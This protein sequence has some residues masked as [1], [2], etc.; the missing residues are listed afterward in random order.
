[1]K[2]RSY[3]TNCLSE[4]DRINKIVFFKVRTAVICLSFFAVQLSLAAEDSLKDHPK[5]VRLELDLKQNV[6]V[7]AYATKISKSPNTHEFGLQALNEVS[8]GIAALFYG[9]EFYDARDTPTKNRAL[10]TQIA[11]DF[12]AMIESRR[13]EFNLDTIDA[14]IAGFQKFQADMAIDAK[15]PLNDRRF[16]TRDHQRL[17][18]AIFGTTA[19]V[20]GNLAYAIARKL[21][22]RSKLLWRYRDTGG[23]SKATR[24]LKT[25]KSYDQLRR[26]QDKNESCKTKVSKL[27]YELKQFGRWA[28]LRSLAATGVG[29]TS[30]SLYFEDF[31]TYDASDDIVNGHII[32]FLK[33]M[34]KTLE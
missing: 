30:Y 31:E 25:L 17:Q 13:M 18:A 21:L 5:V 28:G 4:A 10:L 7:L 3:D 8:Y 15:L 26:E 2:L 32:P 23:W 22:I 1:M 16:K 19:T 12:E 34:R 24:V 29:I 9:D 27:G 11:E 20:G 33:R 6:N 14:L